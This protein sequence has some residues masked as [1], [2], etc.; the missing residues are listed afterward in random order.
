MGKCRQSLILENLLDDQLYGDDFDTAKFV[1]YKRKSSTVGET[2]SIDYVSILD[3][4]LTAICDISSLG[5]NPRAH[6]LQLARFVCL[7]AKEY[8]KFPESVE[9]FSTYILNPK[10]IGIFLNRAIM[11]RTDAKPYRS[12]EIAEIVER[13]YSH[14]DIGIDY[15]E[16]KAYEWETR[17][18]KWSLNSL[19]YFYFDRLINT[20]EPAYILYKVDNRLCRV[21]VVD[22]NS[23]NEIYHFEVWNNP[24]II[25]GVLSG[26]GNESA[27]RSNEYL[28]G[29]PVKP[30]NLVN[31]SDI[32]N[33]A[34]VL[35]RPNSSGLFIPF[36][37]QTIE[38]YRTILR[39]A[40]Y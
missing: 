24:N 16:R 33:F 27:K 31:P 13:S 17:F 11:N 39:Y 12:K 2:V 15:A 19:D 29:E 7:A 35:S 3:P 6:T 26:K 9:E 38:K 36:S 30:E 28:I 14:L 8:G 32:P 10:D 4:T 25:L 5:A 37:K 34:E 23:S 22:K 1:L 40:N 21:V 18:T 20:P